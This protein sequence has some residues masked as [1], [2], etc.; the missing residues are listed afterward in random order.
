MRP[1]P[2]IACGLIGCLYAAPLVAQLPPTPALEAVSIKPDRSADSLLDLQLQGDHWNARNTTLQNLIQAAY[3]LPN[4]QIVGSPDWSRS[5]HFD[6]LLKATG[7]ITPNQLQPLVQEVLRER[8][9]FAAHPERRN[10][11]V[12]ALRLNR[13]DGAFGPQLRKRADDCNA[14]VMNTPLGSQP[15][16]P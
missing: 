9:K 8:F 4:S 2:L 7:Q 16:T 5:E 12:L 13:K 6:V 1:W 14:Q 10:T 15:P 11:S 3:R